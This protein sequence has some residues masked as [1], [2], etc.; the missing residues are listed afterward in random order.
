MDGTPRRCS[1]KGRPQVSET[2][3]KHTP[4][5]DEHV[6]LGA[7][8][9]DFAGWDMPVLYRA[10]GTE[11]RHTREQCSLF[12]V[13]HMGRIE[14]R[15][16]DAEALLEFL[17]TRRLGDAAVGQCR[18][19]HLCNAEGGILDDILVLRYEAHW[20]VVCNACNRVK[21]LAWMQEHAANRNVAI[22][23]TTERTAMIA[24]QGP[25]AMPQVRQRV[26]IALGEL[27]RY[28][29]VTGQYMG[30]NYTVSRTGYTGEDGFEVILPAQ[31]A[32]MAWQFMLTPADEFEPPVVR[33]AG[34]GARDTLR[35]EAAMP[36]YGHELHEKIDPLRAGCAWCVDLTKDFIGVQA[37]RAVN[38]A[39]I[40]PCR[41]GLELA[42][43]RIVR[44]GS[45]VVQG[46]HAIGEVTSGTFSPT[47]ER[48][49][50]M[51]YVPREQAEPGTAVRVRI[52]D[53]EV[54]AVVVALPFYA[55]KKR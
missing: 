18:Y 37:L 47:L 15:G 9:V 2:Q 3:L 7:R 41:V 5:H 31:V 38:D 6:R 54:D 22:D 11:H 33:P 44:Q 1:E 32:A 45:A 46:G 16:D 52:R 24:V 13:S 48:S 26:P 51:A 35:F 49:I 30:M 27:R 36:L 55:R 39:D 53:Q 20:L 21:V 28:R 14:I 34:L 23:D 25:A 40:S 42:G 17:C 43:K 19:S 29:F 8:M 12:D 4:L 10:I 50:A